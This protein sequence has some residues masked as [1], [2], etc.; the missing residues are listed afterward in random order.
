[1]ESILKMNSTYK[2]PIIKIFV[3]HRIDKDCDVINNPFYVNVRCGAIYDQNKGC[4]TNVGGG[5][6][7]RR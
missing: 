3:S 1:M 2:R 5:E 4:K 7:Y 6:Y